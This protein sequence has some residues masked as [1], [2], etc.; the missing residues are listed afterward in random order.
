MQRLVNMSNYIA[1]CIKEPES[2]ISLK[3]S[4]WHLVSTVFYYVTMGGGGRVKA[5]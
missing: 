5:P 3:V 1:R 2:K 4:K